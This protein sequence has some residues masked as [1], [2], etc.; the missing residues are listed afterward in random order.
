M[1]NTTN[2]KIAKKYEHMISHIESEGYGKEKVYVVTL[3]EGYMF[4]NMECG[5]LIAPTVAEV[6]YYVRNEIVEDDLSIKATETNS[7]KKDESEKT[8]SEIIEMKKETIKVMKSN[9][10]TALANAKE[11]KIMEEHIREL[12]SKLSKKPIKDRIK[13]NDLVAFIEFAHGEAFVNFAIKK[14]SCS[15]FGYTLKGKTIPYKFLSTKNKKLDAFAITHRGSKVWDYGHYCFSG[16]EN[17]LT[18]DEMAKLVK[19]F[20]NHVFILKDGAI[21]SDEILRYRDI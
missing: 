12:E 17:K 20:A 19:P 3:K 5:T 14:E 8:L 15:A 6:L 1:I 7:D 13:E 18:A 16:Y 2:I 4:L 11:I 21:I 10:F 9:K